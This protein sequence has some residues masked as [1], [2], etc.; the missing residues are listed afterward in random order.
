[1]MQTGAGKSTERLV[2]LKPSDWSPQL[3]VLCVFFAVLFITGGSSRYDVPHLV[4]LRPLAICVLGFAL[5]TIN[6]GAW[7][8]YRPAIL[9]F[10]SAFALTALHLIPLPPHIWQALPGRQIIADIDAMAGLKDI[11]RP[12]TMFPEGTWNAFYALTVPLAAL[13]L[14]AQLNQR[15]VV[16][17]LVWVT[18]LSLVTGL[19]GV[20]QA[21]GSGIGLY[22]LDP[23]NA[24]LFANRNHQAAMLA[25]LFPM[26]GALAMSGSL[27]S[28]GE[29]SVLIVSAAVKIMLVPLILVTGSRMG[30]VIAVIAFIYTGTISLWQVV[31]QRRHA[32]YSLTL[33]AAGLA[34]AVAMVLVT[35]YTARDEAIDRLDTADEDLRWQFWESVVAFL[36]QYLPWGS[37]VGSFVP[38][39]QI[40]EPDGMLMPQYVNQAHND[41][42]DL[43]LTSGVPGMILAAIAVAA[44]A[45]AMGAALVAP[46]VTGHIRRAGIGTILVLAFASLSDYPLRTPI[47]A[48]V[49][50]VAVIWA[51]A[52]LRPNENEE[53]KGPYAQA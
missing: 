31:G 5:A 1:M 52:P 18:A 7:R 41:W 14:A 4:V 46:G 32:Y 47:L 3:V 6:A 35:I 29:R 21:A 27:F 25:C 40:H 23:V 11:W 2:I 24:G 48:A 10:A 17:L 53:S 13:L 43:A 22:H 16:R 15:D 34:T 51:W 49:L 45:R 39:Y 30:M 26:L 9:L 12:L 33:L 44:F 37:G 8:T 36:P 20:L 19:V 42:L 50:A 28:I 38:V